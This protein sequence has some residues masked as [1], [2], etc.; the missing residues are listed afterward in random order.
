MHRVAMADGGG[1]GRTLG[2]VIREKD[3]ELALFLEMRRRDKER[4]GAA[5][6]MLLAGDGEDP[7]GDGL[8]L[9]DP[10]PPPPPPV[11]PAEPRAA[12][13]PAYRMAGGFRRAPGGA[14][15]FLHSDAGDK[16]DYDWLLTPPGTPLF[17]SHEAA[18]KRSP[19]SQTG[20]PKTRHNSLKS[21]L[22]NHPDPPSRTT[23]PLRTSSSNSLNSAAT[24][25]RP[26]SSGGP[27]SNSSRPS[28]PTGRAASTTASKGSRPS[29]PNARATLPAKTGPTAPRS[30]T[31][32]SRSTLPSTRSALPSSRS[33]TP[34]RTSGPATATRTSGPTAA[35]RTSGPAT[36]TRTSVPS[37]RASAPASRS[38]TPTSRSSMPAT[39][40]TTPLSRPSLPAQSKP[41][42]R[43]STPTRR[44]SAPPTHTQH[45]NLPG[46]VRSSSISRPGPTMPKSSAS[47]ATTTAPAPSRG[48]SPTVKS[49][50]WKPS[51]MPG[52]SLDAPPNLRTSLPE[53][54][55]SATRGRPGA[56]S[57]RSS[58][59]EPGPAAR[60]KR[61]SCSPSRGRT[62][63]GSVPSGSS[64]PAVRR[65]HL[66]GG[67]SV[68][69]VQM[70][71]KMVE[72]VVNM[73]RLAPPKHDDQRSSLNSLSG[74]SLNSPDS[75]GFGRSLSKK[76][77][78]M[79]LRHM[80][81]R[82]SIPNNLRPL[83]TSIPASSVHSGRS[84]ST[85]GRPIS[86]SDS[87]LATSSNAS[88]EPSVNNNLMCF[89]SI[90][91]DDELCSD[92]A[93]HYA[94]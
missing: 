29:S 53:R 82:R 81:I 54:P 45:S 47:A 84:G 89:D 5:A 71:N 78:D 34:S 17:P 11:V 93:G 3:E 61:Q 19:V 74:K 49:R 14:D 39:R 80:D 2:A 50:P 88:S 1:G 6:D 85:R 63:N 18:P 40:S 67:D 77:L 69:P 73:R 48:S 42:S 22:A 91:I 64:M 9:L 38:S 55:T 92:R 32:T 16:S 87:P 31:P 59:V 33:T 75:S 83:M 37:G 57:S 4:A 23:H 12:P 27:T 43:S 30:S 24:T 20:S 35:T 25:R 62:S 36:A 86:V 28:T 46:P 41:A 26:T 79:A 44:S 68:N 21:R 76:S 10:S 72:R 70:G 66:N 8:L 90:D 58:S 60:P 94:R 51:E 56:P 13:A 15:D 7:D 65:S 52:F